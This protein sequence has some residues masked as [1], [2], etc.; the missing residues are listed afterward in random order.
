VMH[1]SYVSE[2]YVW[3]RTNDLSLP[4][5]ALRDTVAAQ[6]ALTHDDTSGA[7]VGGGAVGISFTV[8]DNI[9]NVVCTVKYGR[10]NVDYE[11][12]VLDTLRAMSETLMA[13]I[14]PDF[15]NSSYGLRAILIV[16]DGVHKDTVDVS[17]QV[18]T[19]DADEMVTATGK[20]QPVRVTAQVSDTSVEKCL[21]GLVDAGA[22]W[23][24]DSTEFRLFRW[25]P[26][27]AN[28][29]DT[30]KWV[31]YS[32]PQSALFSLAAGRVSWVKTAVSHTLMFGAGMT[33]SLKSPY[34]VPLT[35]RNWTDI[36]IP[37]KFS[38]MLRD[39]LR[40]SGTSADSLQFWHWEKTDSGYI[41]Q[42]M[43]VLNGPPPLSTPQNDTLKYELLNDAYSVY[44][45]MSHD[46]ELRI[47]PIPVMMSSAPAL[48]KKRTVPDVSWGVIVE[49]E[50]GGSRLNTVY[51]G[52][53]RGSNSERYFT[54]RKGFVPAGV[55]VVD[56]RSARVYGSVMHTTA[57]S[58]GSGYELLF[59]NDGCGQREIT[60]RL[61]SSGALPSGY[62]LRVYNPEN[63]GYEAASQSY[64][65]KVGGA[66]KAYRWV[67]AGSSAYVGGFKSTAL[68]DRYALMG[69]FPNP[70]SRGVKIRFSLPYRDIGSVD[71]G[72]YALSGRRIWDKRLS[73]AIPGG[74]AE[75]TWDGKDLHGRPAA[76]GMYVVRMSA[77]ERGAK[78]PNVFQSRLTKLPY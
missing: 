4:F 44:N 37:F 69:A 39:V 6:I 64:T 75:L 58:E 50:E 32:Q 46:V 73:A 57:M 62:E 66:S 48:S 20:W 2:G 53:E 52:A 54:L 77:L 25:Y 34:G 9:S 42:A 18:L 14:L 24:Y 16:D 61:R 71:I 45:P 51:C 63:G 22:P 60:Y 72:I 40:S 35:A 59:Y 70:F 15:V 31:Q 13:T 76:A 47:P 74:A 65:V 1:D 7:V 49:S 36:A 23:A 55:G 3:V 41:A 33:T 8:S 28:A 43:Y 17:R 5:V 27:A 21:A 67:V 10:G 11:K 78:R 68:S 56:P 30:E 19:A 26:Y 12:T 38:V 29:I